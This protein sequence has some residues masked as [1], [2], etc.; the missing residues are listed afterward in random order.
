[1]DILLVEAFLLDVGLARVREACIDILT[2]RSKH[3]WPPTV[4][5]YESW[6]EPFTALARENG[7]TPE[8]IDEAAAELTELINAIDAAVLDLMH[9]VRLES[10]AIAVPTSELT[11]EDASRFRDAFHEQHSQVELAHSPPAHIKL[12]DGVSDGTCWRFPIVH[13]SDPLGPFVSERVAQAARVA[14]DHV[15]ASRSST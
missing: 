6:R 11:R 1:M 14:L 8:D 13:G 10:D 7:F 9:S 4:T 3:G 5:V 2:V 12:G 15:R